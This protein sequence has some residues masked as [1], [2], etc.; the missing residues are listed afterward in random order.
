[1]KI[2]EA[3]SKKENLSKNITGLK[4]QNNKNLYL[5]R[6][7]YYD[8]YCEN[9]KNDLNNLIAYFDNFREEEAKYEKRWEEIVKELKSINK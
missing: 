1:V 6:N 9:F 2:L 7:Y 5:E 3:E 4:L 8:Q